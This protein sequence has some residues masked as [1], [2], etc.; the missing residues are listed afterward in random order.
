[1]ERQIIWT[2]FQ[3]KHPMQF[4]GNFST[5]EK[6]MTA[7]VNGWYPTGE[8]IWQFNPNRGISGAWEAQFQTK[9]LS[10]SELVCCAIISTRLDP[11]D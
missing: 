5:A 9:P 2:L 11:E 1:M 3:D 10:T 4:D 7:V 6:A 8:I